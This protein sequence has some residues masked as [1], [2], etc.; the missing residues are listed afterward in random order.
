MVL[1]KKG[2]RSKI[3]KAHA[4]EPEFK[5]SRKQRLAVESAINALELHEQDKFHT[6]RG[7]N[8]K[9][10]YKK[11][12]SCF[13]WVSFNQ[14]CSQNSFV[15]LFVMMMEIAYNL[16]VSNFLPVL[17]IFVALT[18]TSEINDRRFKQFYV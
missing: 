8:E 5:K 12:L 11:M 13:L 2:K 18:V 3:D 14:T 1:P 4:S 7:A 6:A 10:C 15:Q 9:T 17:N 16:G